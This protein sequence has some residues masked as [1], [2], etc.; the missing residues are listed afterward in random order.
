MYGNCGTGG[1]PC[2]LVSVTY[3]PVLHKVTSKFQLNRFYFPHCCRIVGGP[4]KIFRYLTSFSAALPLT[5]AKLFQ[6][7]SG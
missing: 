1:T 3:C 4:N 2:N 7:L 5:Q 6:K